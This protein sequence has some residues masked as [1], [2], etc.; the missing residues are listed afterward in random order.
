MV[1]LH[2]ISIRSVGSSTSAAQ[3]LGKCAFEFAARTGIDERIEATVAVA[4][5]ETA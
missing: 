2:V 1:L 4:Q 3:D 5:P